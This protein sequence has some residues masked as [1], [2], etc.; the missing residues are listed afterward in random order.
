MLFSGFE[1]KSEL[2]LNWD[3]GRGACEGEI[4]W[5]IPLLGARMS[6]P[7]AGVLFA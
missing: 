1:M 6:D 2:D 5:E 7:G 4:G 3:C